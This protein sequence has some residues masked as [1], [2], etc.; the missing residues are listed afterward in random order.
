MRRA[1]FARVI[2]TTTLAGDVPTEAVLIEVDVEI[3][4]CPVNPIAKR[5]EVAVVFRVDDSC[6]P[7][8]VSLRDDFPVVPHLNLTE[9][10]SIKNICIFNERWE[11]IRPT[12]SSFG[13]L[14]RIQR[15][16]AGTAAGTLHQSDQPLEPLIGINAPYVLVHPQLLRTESIAVAKLTSATYLRTTV[17]R[18]IGTFSGSTTDQCFTAIIMRTPVV[19]HGIIY[20]EPRTLADLTSLFFEI[21][22]DVSTMVRN[23]LRTFVDDPEW[24]LIRGTRLVVILILPKSRIASGPT[25]STDFR[26]FIS[27]S[28]VESIGIDLG[29]LIRTAGGVG[30]LITFDTS[31]TGATSL[32]KVG[33]TVPLMDRKSA[34]EYSGRRSD[35]VT[36]IVQVGVGALGSQLVLNLI[37]QGFGLWTLIDSD[38]LLP[39]NLARHAAFRAQL[40]QPKSDGLARLASDVVADPGTITPLVVDVLEPAKFGDKVKVAFKSTDIIVDCSASIAVERT[41]CLDVESDAR[42]VAFFMNPSG[43]DLVCLAEDCVRRT[44]L[45]VLEMA[46]YRGLLKHASLGGHLS[47][48]I[49]VVRYG[50]SCRD[51]SSRIRQDAV[52]LH[53][54]ISSRVLGEMGERPEGAVTVWRLS[55]THA[56]D[57][58]DI[59]FGEERRVITGGWTVCYDTTFE[60]KVQMLRRD[61]LPNET[62][63]VLL[64]HVDLL[65]RCLYVIDSVFAPP[66][67]IEHPYAFI[68]GFSGIRAKLAKLTNVTG[69]NLQYVGEWHSHPDGC[70]TRMSADDVTLLGWVSKEVSALD[71]PGVVLIVGKHEI[72]FHLQES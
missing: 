39:H 46:Y 69:G 64:G 30:P 15:W 48:P 35:Q 12:L 28:S 63:G 4:Q 49:G 53:A 20:R 16:F 9:H 58:F 14:E 55:D 3:G 10:E 5:E 67:S 66:D 62:G 26:A 52:A 8:I 68:R 38:L 33:N 36:K 6:S 50:S 70:S 34:C 45:D 25:E 44:K 32:I 23:Q 27:E 21:G 51:T 47:P 72:R 18:E 54:A 7:Q 40:G 60:D 42:R 1:E 19:T 43:Q 61:K 37:R 13:L 57:R 24:S 31:K 22:F 11:E 41:L 17:M 71:Q 65:R 29:V 56:L 59:V 2:G